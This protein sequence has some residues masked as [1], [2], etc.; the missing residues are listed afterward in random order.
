M[1]IARSPNA[2]A[3][4][5][6]ATMTEKWQRISAKNGGTLYGKTFIPLGKEGDM[7]DTIMTNIIQQQNN[8]NDV[9]DIIEITLGEDVYMDP[10]GITL[11]DIFFNYHDKNG[12]CLIDAIEKTSTRGTYRFLFQQNKTEEVDKMLE[13]INETL[14]SIG[15]WEE[16]HTH[17]CFLLSIP[18]S[19]VGRI[20][21]TTQP[22]FWA[23][24]LS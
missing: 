5:F 22:A 9:D 17:V 3:G 16:C 12:N 14:T 18:I 2:T 23:N 1:Q 20:P 19:L 15:D 6:R 21:R 10:A 11:I 4:Y 13:H 24:H 8:L 7:G